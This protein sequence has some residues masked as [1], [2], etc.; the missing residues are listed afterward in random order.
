MLAVMIGVFYFEEI[1]A[2]IKGEEYKEPEPLYKPETKTLIKDVLIMVLFD[3]LVLFII[4]FIGKWFYFNIRPLQKF[5]FFNPLV[6]KWGLI[7]LFLLPVFV[8]KF[9]CIVEKKAKNDDDIF[10]LI[11]IFNMSILIIFSF[12]AFISGHSSSFMPPPK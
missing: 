4:Y 10:A 2:R 7:A 1:K 12:V 8:G 9:C 5:I 3:A 11:T 6:W